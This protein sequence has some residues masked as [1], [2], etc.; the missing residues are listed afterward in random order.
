LSTVEI[1]DGMVGFPRMPLK[2][3]VLLVI[4]VKLDKSPQYLST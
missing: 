1:S 3:F 2:L 4:R